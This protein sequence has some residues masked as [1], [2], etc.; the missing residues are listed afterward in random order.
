MTYDNYELDQIGV[1]ID[2]I[3]N[4][5]HEPIMGPEDAKRSVRAYWSVFGHLPE[6]GRECICDCE[7]QEHAELIYEAVQGKT[8]LVEALKY[9]RLWHQGDKWRFTEARGRD[10]AEEKAWHA[11]MR[12][13]DDA[14]EKAGVTAK[15]Q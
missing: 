4:E 2:G 10:N 9:C 3:G 7:T 1:F 8:A 5:N 14:L 6:G 15:E 12:R 11:Q 13:I